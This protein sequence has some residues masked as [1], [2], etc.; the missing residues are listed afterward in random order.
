LK[1]GESREKIG[2]ILERVDS[3]EEVSILNA[4]IVPHRNR[5]KSKRES[6]FEEEIEL[7][8]IV[9]E[10]IRV[11]CMSQSVLSVDIVNN[12]TFILLSVVKCVER[13]TEI[14][15]YFSSLFEIHPSWTARI[16]LVE[17]VDHISTRYLMPLLFQEKCRDRR[18]NTSR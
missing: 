11:G 10:H 12:P 13:E 2:L 4:S 8:Q 14:L 18:V 17:I 6:F 15:G 1:C 7:H 3:F 9:A 5:V 16:L